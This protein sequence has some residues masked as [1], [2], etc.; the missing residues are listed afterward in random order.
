MEYRISDVSSDQR[1]VYI[2]KTVL[3]TNNKINQLNP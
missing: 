2:D 1:K 3:A